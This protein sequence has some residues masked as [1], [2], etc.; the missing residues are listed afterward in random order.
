MHM[1]EEPPG[2]PKKKPKK[3]KK[4]QVP[5]NLQRAQHM[6]ATECQVVLVARMTLVTQLALV[7]SSV[8]GFMEALV[9]WLVPEAPALQE[10]QVAQLVPFCRS[11]GHLT[12]QGLVEMLHLEPQ[13]SLTVAFSSH[14]EAD[15]ARHF[16]TPRT[17]LRGPIRKELDVNG[18]M[19][20]LRLTAEDPGLL[21]SSIVF[22]LE[23]LSLVMRSLQHFGAPLSQHRR[24][25]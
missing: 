5:W 1:M 6:V 23:Q 16:L 20:V 7:T 15:I 12:L 24:G 3:P 8:T 10:S 11:Q 21:Q 25:V 17:Q 18:R 4:T 2:Q 13:F 22:C 9:T 19:L 14:A